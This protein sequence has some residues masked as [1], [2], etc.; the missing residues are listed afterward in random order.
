MLSI[1]ILV[2]TALDVD[3]AAEGA[4]GVI[5][6]AA[7][8]LSPEEVLAFGAPEVR[9]HVIRVQVFFDLAIALLANINT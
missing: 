7:K 2:H 8:D 9:Q 1:H 4:S 3:S 6:G 5:L